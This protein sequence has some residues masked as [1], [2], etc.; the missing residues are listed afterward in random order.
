MRITR[1][2]RKAIV[3]ALQNEEDSLQELFIETLMKMGLSGKDI[4]SYKTEARNK[5]RKERIHHEWRLKRED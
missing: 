1:H 4:Q 2:T 3:R 5:P